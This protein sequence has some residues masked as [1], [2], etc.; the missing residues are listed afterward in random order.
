[1]GD[2]LTTVSVSQVIHIEG[3]WGLA[4]A[5]AERSQL[6]RDHYLN[7]LATPQMMVEDT[8]VDHFHENAWHAFHALESLLSEQEMNRLVELSSR[9]QRRWVR[10]VSDHFR[11]KAL[12]SEELLEVRRR[13]LERAAL[14]GREENLSPDEH[15][16]WMRKISTHFDRAIVPELG[17]LPD[18]KQQDGLERLLFKYVRIGDPV[19]E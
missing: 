2:L 3:Y 8:S 1:M 9:Q 6:L 16:T 18:D 4:E 14:L 13:L 12:S 17:L 11:R 5:A 10:I 7:L 19:T 15:E